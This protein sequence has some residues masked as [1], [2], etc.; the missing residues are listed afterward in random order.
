MK[1]PN[2]ERQNQWL[3]DYVL[4]ILS[5]EPWKIA[6][7]YRKNHENPFAMTRKERAQLIELEKEL[8][9]GEIG[10]EPQVYVNHCE[11]DDGQYQLRRQG[12]VP[13]PVAHE[14][15]WISED[16]YRAVMDRGR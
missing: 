7:N 10:S 5:L 13:A 6:Q 3:D 16:V 8:M 14:M 15:G 11:I 9:T 2:R 1:F 4:P 12:W